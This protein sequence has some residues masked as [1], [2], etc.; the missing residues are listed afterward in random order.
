MILFS[1]PI[2]SFLYCDFLTINKVM[3]DWLQQHGI[4]QERILLAEEPLDTTGNEAT[5][6]YA[7]SIRPSCYNN[8]L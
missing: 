5:R 7:T 8:K 4:K 3:S 2:A 1:N 6:D